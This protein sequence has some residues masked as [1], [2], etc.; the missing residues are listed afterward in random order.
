MKTEENVLIDYA[1]LSIGKIVAKD[2]RKAMVFK[3]F[4]IDFCCGGAVKLKDI[5]N[6]YEVNTRELYEALYAVDNSPSEIT[7]DYKSWSTEKLIDHIINTHH[8]YVRETIE[9]LLPMITKVEMV[10]GHW[11][12]ELKEIK[13]L[14]NELADELLPHMQKEE[15]ILF[16]AI[17]KISS[18]NK[19]V[20]NNPFG[21]VKNPINMMEHEHDIAGQLMKQINTLTNN[22]TTP[23]GACATFV[24]VYKVLNA[25]ESD[26]FTHI[27]LENNILFPR[28][29]ELE[30]N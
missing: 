12:P 9:Q 17:R 25:F 30:L 13:S 5:T 2:F 29:I 10:H 4:G 15:M 20:S 7:E 3:S 22:Y 18:A 26:L 8:N 27:H 14:F 6:D 21:S 28:A 11:R 23:K 16:P 24:V 1:E 19:E